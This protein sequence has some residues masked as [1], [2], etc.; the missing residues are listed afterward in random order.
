MSTFNGNIKQYT[1]AVNDEVFGTSEVTHLY[2]EG[3][4]LIP[5]IHW[6]TNGSN[7]TNRYVKWE[8]EYSWANENWTFSTPTIISAEQEILANKSS[9]T[10]YMTNLPNIDGTNIK[11]GT[12]LCWRVRRIISS[13]VAPTSNPFGLAFGVHVHQSVLR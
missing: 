1:F 5:H 6:A 11:I 13:G 2:K 7:T 8:L 12:Y 3:T 10:H 4:N 9:L